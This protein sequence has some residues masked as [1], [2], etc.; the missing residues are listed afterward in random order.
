MHDITYSFPANL[1]QSVAT[2]QMWCSPMGICYS[3]P[4]TVGRGAGYL[5]LTNHM[6]LKRVQEETICVHF[7]ITSTSDMVARSHKGNPV[8]TNKVTASKV[9]KPV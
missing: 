5:S 8:S 3:H 9:L 2:N 6:T 7:S 1:F 4:S